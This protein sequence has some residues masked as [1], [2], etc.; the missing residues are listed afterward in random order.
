MCSLTTALTAPGQRFGISCGQDVRRRNP[1]RR[2]I[3]RLKRHICHFVRCWNAT[4][5]SLAPSLHP[6]CARSIRPKSPVARPAKRSVDT[7]VPAV[8]WFVANHALRL[9]QSAAFH[10]T[11]AVRASLRLQRSGSATR[12]TACSSLWEPAAI[13]TRVG[14]VAGVIPCR[15]PDGTGGKRR[16]R[17][18]ADLLGQPVPRAVFQCRPQIAL[19]RDP[20]G[21]NDTTARSKTHRA[22][23]P[24]V[25]LPPASSSADSG[26]FPLVGPARNRH[27]RKTRFEP[28][29]AL[30][31]GRRAIRNRRLARQ[32]DRTIRAQ[33]PESLM[34]C[35]QSPVPE[36]RGFSGWECS[37]RSPVPSGAARS[38]RHRSF[39]TKNSDGSD[40]IRPKRHL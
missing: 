20:L 29:Q 40:C 38:R 24:S 4:R 15:T 36:S 13:A 21:I 25:R 9:G 39:G 6:R 18:I 23:R 14:I 28:R 33:V 32:V 30:A 17:A 10:A 34:V 26:I 31:M 37:P 16:L 19:A 12:L 2:P 27:C 5:R 35:L 11:C 22:A 7:A 3:Q 8:L 1:H